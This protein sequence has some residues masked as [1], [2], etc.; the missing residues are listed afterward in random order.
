[1]RMQ[2]HALESHS[3]EPRIELAVAVTVVTGHRVTRMRGL[4][5]DLVRA[6][7]AYRDFHERGFRADA[8]EQPELA[9]R[10]L[11]AAA[12]GNS[13]FS[14]PMRLYQRN[15]DSRRSFG[16]GALEQRQITLVDSALA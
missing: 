10:Q 7:R 11:P 8:L 1:M 6:T 3:F 15:F 13:R 14:L 12:D 4:N 16:P 2:E 5:A 9:R